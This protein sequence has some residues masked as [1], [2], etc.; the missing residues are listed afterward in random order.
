M[1]S[2]K[3]AYHLE[4][5]CRTRNQSTCSTDPDQSEIWEVIWNLKIPRAAQIFLWRACN[6]I[7]PTREKLFSRTL[8][9]D[10]LCPTC[11]VET[12]LSAHIIWSCPASLTIWAECR[13]S[14]QKSVVPECEFLFILE[15]LITRLCMEDLEL[16]AI[17]AQQIWFQYNKVV[18]GRPIMNPTSLVQ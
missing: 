5:D 14:I 15:H 7:L 3:S 17:V 4:L 12:E 6:E 9:E 10:P 11:G 1:F 18:F 13:R 2:A 8:V 16:M